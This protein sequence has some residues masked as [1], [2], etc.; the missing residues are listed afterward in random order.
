MST[1]PPRPLEPPAHF[2][3][4]AAAAVEPPGPLREFWGYFSAN[5]GAV[6]GLVI[7]LAV[8]SVALLAPW[9]A[10]F[11]PDLSNA[12]RNA[13]KFGTTAGVPLLV[14]VVGLV[15]WRLR[16]AKKKRLADPA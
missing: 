4:P 11:A 13:T 3:R 14:L 8:I 7:V 2:A 1:A 15:R 12:T 16:A 6:A 10:P 9:I 5:P